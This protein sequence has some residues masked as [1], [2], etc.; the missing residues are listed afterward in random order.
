MIASDRS[1][2]GGGNSARG[3]AL[4]LTIPI[5]HSTADSPLP[6]RIPPGDA[7]QR[8]A[9]KGEAVVV[10]SVEES[11]VQVLQADGGPLGV[12]NSPLK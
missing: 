4:I 5:D 6:R 9:S 1:S 11:E 12:T 8:R 7:S 2:G 3:E 10:D